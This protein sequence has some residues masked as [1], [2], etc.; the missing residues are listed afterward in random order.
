MCYATITLTTNMAAGVTDVR[1]SLHV[2]KEVGERKNS[3]MK[4]L[5]IYAVD[6]LVERQSCTCSEPY[7]RTGK[8]LIAK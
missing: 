8:T 5:V 1:P 4:S 2:H 3:T 6:Q 7:E